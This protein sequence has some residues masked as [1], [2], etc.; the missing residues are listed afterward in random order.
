MSCLLFFNAV[1][2]GSLFYGAPLAPLQK[3]FFICWSPY[4][5]RP[6]YEF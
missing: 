2:V 4:R 1:R 6:E 3:I 5:Y